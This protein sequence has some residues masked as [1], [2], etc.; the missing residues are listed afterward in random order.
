M[1][2]TKN[3]EPMERKPSIHSLREKK[4][5]RLIIIGFIITAVL[6]VGMTAYGLLYDSVI[7]QHIPVAKVDNKKIDNEYFKDRVRLERNAYIQQYNMMYAQYQ[8]FS[9]EESYAEYYK[10]QLS[11]VQSVLDDYEGF[12]ENVLDQM[13]EDQVIAIEAGKMG[14]DISEEEIDGLVKE[15]FNYYPDGTPTPEPTA[16]AY[17][18]PTVSKTEE[19]LLGYTPTPKATEE[20]AESSE[21]SEVTAAPEIAVEETAVAETEVTPEATAAAAEA[22]PSPTA[23]PY[24][25]E[26]FQKTYSEYITNLADINVR[27]Q[28]LRKYIYH[29]LL[30]DKVK[31]KIYSEVSV[32]QEQVWARHILVETEDEAKAVKTRLDA[33]EDWNKIA[34]EVSLDTSN[35][36]NGGDL[37]WFPRN[38][39][40]TE[41]EDAAFALQPGQISDPVETDY[42]WHIIQCIGHET[43]PL[44]E[45]DYQSA[46]DAY[47]QKWL[48]EKR[49]EKTVK[50][51]D[52]W[53][54]L[55]P[56]DPNISEEYRVE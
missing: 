17:T 43:R 4:Q 14:I 37:G 26:L 18:T 15:L 28:Y 12:G 16:T 19:A 35:K 44:A 31:E 46:Q 3:E 52:V 33:G 48:E 7:K 27:E 13:I 50:I 41:F 11:Q 51:N 47:Y 2:S 45:A 1:A 22:T 5:N 49:T 38:F 24:T 29:Y 34:A 55:V 30:D 21:I 42:G 40:V 20:I 23:T 9:S 10:S 36:D 6:I 53:K 56:Q 8:M 32:D 39:M 54:E 25:E